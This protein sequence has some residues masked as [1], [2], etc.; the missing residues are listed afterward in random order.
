MGNAG[1]TFAATFD[2][3]L[4]PNAAVTPNPPVWYR[5]GCCGPG[6]QAMLIVRAANNFPLQGN[7]L[8]QSPQLTWLSYVAGD[9]LTQ[10][11]RLGQLKMVGTNDALEYLAWMLTACV[12]CYLWSF[13]CIEITWNM[14]VA[15]SSPQFSISWKLCII[16]SFLFFDDIGS[17]KLPSSLALFSQTLLLQMI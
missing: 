6:W 3:F 9:H 2:I 16:Y 17:F 5:S 11:K 13:S 12:N 1:T 4:L 8:G 7:V 14:F 10:L 15:S